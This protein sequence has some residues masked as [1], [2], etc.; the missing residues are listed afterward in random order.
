MK[1]TEVLAK[2]MQLIHAE[3]SGLA[4]LTRSEWMAR[5]LPNGNRVGF[6]AWHM[7]ATRDW[8]VRAVLQAARPLGWDAPFAGTGVARC[9]IAFG[10]P[11][12]EADA[13][14][15][16][17]EPGEVVAYSEAVTDEL[18]RWLERGAES[19]LA[20]PAADGRRHLAL[21]PRYGDAAFRD[22][23]GGESA[24]L[25]DWSVWELLSRPCFGH[26]MSHR[27]EIEFARKQL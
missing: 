4:G 1:A 10:M 14:A 17:L 9:P 26:C 24:E 25:L 16:A 12:A 21:S 19:D 2:Q 5:P 27:E 22:E 3:I 13:I 8:T 15:A 18:L 11:S 23:I 20:R 7:V 6:T